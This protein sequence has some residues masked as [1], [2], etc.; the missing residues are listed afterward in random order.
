MSDRYATIRSR[1]LGPGRL[2]TAIWA[3]TFKSRAL[4]RKMVLNSDSLI[5]GVYD[6]LII[7]M[8]V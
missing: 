3:P 5:Q 4:Y 8:R 6:M 7:M 2:G 1:Q